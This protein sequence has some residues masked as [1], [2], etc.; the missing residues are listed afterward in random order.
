MCSTCL[1]LQLQLNVSKSVLLD[2]VD[3][4]NAFVGQ[5]GTGREL[6][7]ADDKLRHQ[8]SLVVIF[9]SFETWYGCFS[10]AVNDVL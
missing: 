10:R 5:R 1:P 7:A 6:T 4:Y 9:T 2:Y 8:C 3:K